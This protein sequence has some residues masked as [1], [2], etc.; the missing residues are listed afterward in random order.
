[1]L[2][3]ADKKGI[4]VKSEDHSLTLC[5]SIARTFSPLVTI[6][7]K[8]LT[9]NRSGRPPLYIF[10]SWSVLVPPLKLGG[11]PL[12]LYLDISIPFI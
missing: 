3:D 1:M 5:I 12:T 7:L 4:S 8:S 9:G 2:Y 10:A 11:T 6:F